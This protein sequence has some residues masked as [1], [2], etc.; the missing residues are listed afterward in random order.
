MLG[1]RIEYESE[2]HGSEVRD[3]IVRIQREEFGVDNSSAEDLLWSITK[4]VDAAG[5]MFSIPQSKGHPIDPTVRRTS[6]SLRDLE[7]T[8]WSVDATKP[9]LQHP[10]EGARIER[11]L[12][13]RDGEARLEDYL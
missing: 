13:P 4:R 12:P 10:D 11:T 1:V 9:P 2:N 8:K 3:L 7:F 6:D 5:H